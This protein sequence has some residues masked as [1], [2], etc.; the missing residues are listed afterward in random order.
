MHHAANRSQADT[1]ASEE[2][3]HTY[4]KIPKVVDEALAKSK[5]VRLTDRAETDVSSDKILDKFDAWQDSELWPALVKKFNTQSSGDAA[6]AKALGM[7]VDVQ[8]RSSLLRQ[9]TQLGEVTETRLLTAPGAQRKRHI[10]IRLPTGIEYRAGDYLAVLPMNPPDLVK[11]VLSRFALPWDAMITIDESNATS[12]PKNTPISAH[13]ILASMVELEQPV[14]SRIATAVVKS[15]PDEKEAKAL[16][17]SMKKAGVAPS[18]LVILEEHLQAQFS[19]AQFLAA[20]PPMRMRQYSISSTPLQDPSLVTLTYSVI[21]AP[22]KS[23]G[24]A[25]FVGICTTYMERLKVGDRLHVSLKGSRAGFHLPADDST[26][27]IMAC[28]GTG[29]APFRAFVAERAVK[30]IN[31]NDVGPAMLFY[32]LNSPDEDDMYR[33]EFEKWEAAGVVSVHR[34]YT[35]KSQESGGAKYVQERIWNDREEVTALFRKQAQ[36]YLCGAGVVGSGVEKTM[37]RIRSEMSGDD[38]E[39]AGK[40]VQG[41]KGDRYWSDVFS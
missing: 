10:G 39:A 9:E 36:I 40:W 17:E 16:Q 24:K 21:D 23:G 12:L 8:T 5:A 28:A 20:M 4:Q 31:G 26:A 30:K 6:S 22:N 15:I 38:E 11:R 19:F 34:A 37:A 33:E 41:L 13:D 35:H 29:L 25:N 1:S 7:T 14:S 18:L 2:W 3:A 27:I 32:G